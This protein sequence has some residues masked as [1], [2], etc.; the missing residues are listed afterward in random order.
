MS[1]SR[2][3]IESTQY[4]CTALVFVDTEPPTCGYCPTDITIDNTT[5]IEI[6]VN[7]DRPNCTDNSGNPPN[8]NS[9]RQSGDLFSVPS[10]SEVVYTVDDGKNVNK[11]C[12][13]RITLKSEY[14]A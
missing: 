14:L 6:R 7:W 11:N 4:H 9:N 8:I 5:E 10:S 1:R 13:F 3:K 12:S 2:T